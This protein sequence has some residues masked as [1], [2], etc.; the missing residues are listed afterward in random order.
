MIN[1]KRL[2]NKMRAQA[3]FMIHHGRSAHAGSNLSVAD[4]VTVL[5][6]GILR[7]D[8][9]RPEWPDR[10]RF[11]MSK[12]HAAAIVWAN[13]ASRGFFPVSHLKTYYKDGGK[14]AGHVTK[15]DVPGVELSTG[16]LGHGLPFGAG[17]ALAGKRDGRNYRVFV[18]LSDGE[19]DEGS[20][21]EAI[22]F[23]QHHKLDN[24][25]AIVDYNKIQSLAT[26]KET[27]NLEPLKEKFAAFG[28]ATREI[29]GHN[30]KEIY[31][32]L[33]N[34]PFR[35]GKPSAVIA[36]TIKGKGV[37][38]MENAVAWHYANTDEEKLAIALR[39]LKIKPN[40]LSFFKK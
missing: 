21:W 6:H 28:W 33:K 14:L 22:L 8:P 9:K 39:E 13:L 3:L 7:V 19:L 18:V 27:L 20:N 37:S 15:L 2:S 34:I 29:D 23:A 40:E 24:L 35:K 16:S 5:Y 26:V 32:T 11:I 31:T 25:V 38:F 36:H 4:I 12:G 10:D 30:H 17:V 1:Y